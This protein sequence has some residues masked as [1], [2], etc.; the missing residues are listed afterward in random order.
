M[1]TIT[2]IIGAVGFIL[3][4]VP[5]CCDVTEC[6]LLAIPIIFGFLLVVLSSKLEKGWVFGEKEN[7]NSYYHSD[8]SYDGITWITDEC[9]RAGRYVDFR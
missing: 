1:K 8:D 7:F 2:Y 4:F 6:P 9:S 5:M 3:A